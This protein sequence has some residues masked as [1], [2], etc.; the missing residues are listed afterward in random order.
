MK[1]QL[2]LII[3]SLVLLLQLPAMADDGVKSIIAETAQGEKIECYLADS[4]KLTQHNDRVVLTSE[5]AEVEFSTQN[6]LKVYLAEARLKLSYWLD[7]Q[8]YK[9]FYHNAGVKVTPLP[10]PEREGY[11]F[12]GWTG[13]PA[14]MPANDVTVYGSFSIGT[15]KVIFFVG[16]EIYKTI[17]VQYGAVIPLPEMPQI[18]GYEFQWDDVPETMPAHDIVINGSYVTINGISTADTQERSVTQGRSYIHLS[19]LSA[20]E[21]VAVY[22]AAGELLLTLT[23][24]A[25]GQLPISLSS[26]VKGVNII[27]TK[28]QTFKITRK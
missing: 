6:L 12:S 8:L 27:K 4:P 2:R 3:A 11:T 23:A 7:Q 17:D 18:P 25:D 19:G 13:E 1:K 16:G 28:H 20:N 22:T 15:Y 5:Q 24:S 10:S 21:T 26:L 9:E 14:V